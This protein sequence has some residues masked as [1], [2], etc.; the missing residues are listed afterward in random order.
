MSTRAIIHIVSEWT[1]EY[2]AT[3]YKQCDGY[4]S[5]LGEELKSILSG[6]K[7]VNGIPVGEDTSNLAN[8]MGCLAAQIVHALKSKFPIGNVYL[9][10][11]GSQGCGE[12]YTYT[13]YAADPAILT[14]RIGGGQ[15]DILMEIRDKHTDK[16]IY[17]GSPDMFDSRLLEPEE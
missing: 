6:K 1:G 12:E 16:I 15:S 4:P 5:G 7:I 2:L 3:I 10:K 8:G 11:T 13:I 14:K 17:S 9:H